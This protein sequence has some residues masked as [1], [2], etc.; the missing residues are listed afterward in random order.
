MDNKEI[1]NMLDRHA[2]N[3]TQLIYALEKAGGDPRMILHEKL[4]VAELLEIFTRN[5]IRMALTVESPES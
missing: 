1:T 4:L 3:Y 2:Y 5:G